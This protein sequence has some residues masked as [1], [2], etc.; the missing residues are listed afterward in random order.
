MIGAAGELAP[1]QRDRSTSIDYLPRQ[2]HDDD[3]RQDPSLAA[4]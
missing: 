4:G 3:R 2:R 1:A